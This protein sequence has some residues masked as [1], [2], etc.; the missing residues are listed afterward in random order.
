MQYLE[1]MDSS[2]LEVPAVRNV[3]FFFIVM[4]LGNLTLVLLFLR[5]FKNLSSRRVNDISVNNKYENSKNNKKNIEA[6]GLVNEQRDINELSRNLE[7]MKED[8]KK[9]NKEIYR[10]AYRDTLTGLLNRKGFY[11]VSESML[12]ESKVD[13]VLLLLD[14]DDFKLINDTLGHDTGDIVLESFSKLLVKSVPKNSL[15]ARLGGDEFVVM[16][17]QPKR[18]KIENLMQAILK[19]LNKPI[20]I[21]EKEYIVTSSIGV[22]LTKNSKSYNISDL[23]KN[24]DMAMYSSKE[25]GKNQATVFTDNLREL[26]IEEITQTKEL[27]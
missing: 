5:L 11:E 10:L 2:L 24:A 4:F 7:A 25:Q 1:G 16:F 17:P 22:A 6:G 12:S 14:I 21:L 27:Y 20:T 3:L 18:N 9:Q 13:Y 8:L 26:L 23:L 15:I 19:N